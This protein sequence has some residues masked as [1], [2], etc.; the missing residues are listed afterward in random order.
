MIRQSFRALAA[1]LLLGLWLWLAAAATPVEQG[2][3]LTLR[4]ALGS[5]CVALVAGCRPQMELFALLAVPI[6]AMLYAI[7]Q[8]ALAAREAKRRGM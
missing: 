8:Q 6:C 1:L 7:L 2:G 3:L 5:L 4:L